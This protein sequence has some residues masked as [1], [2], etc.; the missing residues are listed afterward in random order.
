MWEQLGLVLLIIGVL[1]VIYKCVIFV[2]ETMPENYGGNPGFGCL[3]MMVRPWFA[4]ACI[5][6]GLLIHSWK[7]GVGTFVIGFLLFG[8][9]AMLLARLFGG[10]Y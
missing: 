2:K 9:L 7:W 10:R 4:T 3:E 5:G 8:F 1:G 6:F